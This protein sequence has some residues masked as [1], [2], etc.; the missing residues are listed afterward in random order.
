M[1]RNGFKSFNRV[2]D[3]GGLGGPTAGISGIFRGLDVS[4]QHL[5]LSPREGF[6]TTSKK[7]RGQYV[8]LSVFFIIR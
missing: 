7:N 5:R 3:Q 1:N 6:E 2:Q 8:K 4:L